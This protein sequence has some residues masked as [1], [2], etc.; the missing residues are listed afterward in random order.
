MAPFLTH[1][2][3]GERVWR[4]RDGRWPDRKGFGTFL[5][6]CLA[7]DVDKFCDGLEQATTHF[8][9]KDEDSCWVWQRSQHFLKHQADILRAPFHALESDEKAFVL[10]YICHVATDEIMGRLGLALRSQLARTGTPLPHIDGLLTAMDPRFWVLARDSE[11]LIA[12]L[13]SATIPGGTFRFLPLDCLVA[14]HHIVWPQ[15]RDGGGL[16]A[17]TNMV[18]RQWQW[19][20]HGRVSDAPDD[21][22][23]EA[24]LAAYRLQIETDLPASERLVDTIELE[25]FVQEA[26]SYSTQH[27]DTLLDGRYW[28]EP[29]RL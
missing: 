5:F 11:G 26:A 24:E 19:M 29:K 3:V 22:D 28:H 7:P 9:A 14:M 2:V 17:Y 20:R 15:V 27:M 1:L 12:A 25:P 23:L 4:A 8:V 21:P 16:I 18:R 10:G 6:G 13:M